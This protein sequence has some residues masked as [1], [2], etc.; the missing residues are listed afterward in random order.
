MV[1]SVQAA[2][3]PVKLETTAVIRDSDSTVNATVFAYRQPLPSGFPPRR[4]GYVY[5]GLDVRVWIVS[6]RTPTGMSWDPWRLAYADDT[7][8][9]PVNVR[10]DAW[11][12]VP[13]Y[14]G[15]MRRV[16]PGRCVRGWIIFQVPKHKRPSGAA[17]EP[18]DKYG[19]PLEQSAE[20]KL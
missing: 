9:E 7:S 18:T 6:A 3:T 16:R 13:L 2:P 1:P 10:S 19:E 14:P 17:Y 11:F 12:N 20:W 8:I 5:R 15:T 4:S